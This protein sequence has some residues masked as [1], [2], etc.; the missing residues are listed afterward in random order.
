M[1]SVCSLLPFCA[2]V[3]CQLPQVYAQKA[4]ATELH[5]SGSIAED[6]IYSFVYVPFEVPQDVISL[7]VL[8]NY[9][10]RGAGN[11]LDLGIFDPKGL[12]AINA[13][14]GF[15]GSR[16]WSGGSRSNFTIS[17]ADATP[18]YVR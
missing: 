13:K 16:G 6:Q 1:T 8:Q 17:A 3:A 4:K 15:T 7:Y 12:D 2:L 18:G 9:S 11:A 14:T 5:L 10:F